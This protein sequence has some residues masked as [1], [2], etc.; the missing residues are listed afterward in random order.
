MFSDANSIAGDLCATAISGVVAV[1]VLRIWEETAKRGLFDQVSCDFRCF[2]ACAAGIVL[3]CCLSLVC[4]VCG[5]CEKCS[6]VF[7]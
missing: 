2:C 6:W 5:N 3:C 4:L 7:V 1:S